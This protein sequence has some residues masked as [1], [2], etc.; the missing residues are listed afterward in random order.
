MKRSWIIG[1][2]DN[3]D[4]I[5]DDPYVSG[6]HAILR[7]IDNEV[8][9]EDLGSTNGTWLMTTSGAKHKVSAPI[10]IFPGDILIVGR[11]QIPWSINDNGPRDQ[12][13][14]AA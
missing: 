4:I 7:R 3:C 13:P 5:V 8:Y 12:G 9:A 10:R 2:F 14:A 11:T 1:Q 6:H